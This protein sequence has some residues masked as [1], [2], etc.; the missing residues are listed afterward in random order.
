MTAT[1]RSVLKNARKAL[2]LNL[3]EMIYDAKQKNKSDKVPYGYYKRLVSDIA[4]EQPSITESVLKKAFQKYAFQK[5]AETKKKESDAREI[6]NPA[7]LT[8]LIGGRDLRMSLISKPTTYSSTISGDA[9][10]STGVEVPGATSQPQQTSSQLSSVEKNAR[11]AEKNARKA[12]LQNLC[13]MI[14]TAKQKNKSD[15]VPYGYYQRIVSNI[16]HE[17]PWITQSVLKKAFKKYEET[18][19]K[20]TDARDTL[21]SASGFIVGRDLRTSLINKPTASSSTSSGDA[22]ESTGVEISGATSQPQQPSSQPRSKGGRKKGSTNAMKAQTKKSVISVQ[23]EIVTV[24]LAEKRKCGRQRMKNNRLRELTDEL[25]QKRNIA[26]VDINLR[27]LQKRIQL[28]KIKNS[29]RGFIS[30][31]AKVEPLIIS[32]ILEFP[33]KGSLISCA[34]GLSIANSIIRG[35]ETEREVIAWK[36]KYS[37]MSNEWSDGDDLLGR[38][39]WKG[40]MKRNGC[41]IVSK[42]DCSPR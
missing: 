28:K 25:K 10:E 30:P 41:K 27:T 12:I 39:Y 34:T 2:L 32:R 33:Q 42:R 16:A 35:T 37:H 17:Q 7:S 5:Y 13:E 31:M 14:N 36:R 21:N 19:K 8:E 40:F 22:N 15:K 11:R 20:E 18:E 4:H 24:Y 23:N 38:S 6:L 1:V 9:N 26:D 3:C 29:H